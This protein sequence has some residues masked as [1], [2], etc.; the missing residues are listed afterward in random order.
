MKAKCDV[1]PSRLVH[2][3]L[4]F[5]V[6][7]SPGLGGTYIF[8][9]PGFAATSGFFPG[10]LV[11]AKGSCAERNEVETANRTNGNM[12]HEIRMRIMVTSKLILLLYKTHPMP[13]VNSLC[14]T[15]E[16]DFVRA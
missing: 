15:K 6:N 3:T 16:N 13:L 7:G 5:P 9:V 8:S 10:G 14:S 4:D 12:S 1:D 2:V 11:S